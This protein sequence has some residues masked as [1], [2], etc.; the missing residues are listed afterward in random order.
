V[1][2]FRQVEIGGGEFPL[3]QRGDIDAQPSFGAA[4][5]SPKTRGIIVDDG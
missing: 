1:I 2:A 3:R 5:L 4:T